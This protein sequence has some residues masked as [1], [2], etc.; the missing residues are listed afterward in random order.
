V[1]GDSASEELP[2]AIIKWLRKRSIFHRKFADILTYN[3]HKLPAR[4]GF[5]GP[6]DGIGAPPL[7]MIK[8][9]LTATISFV[10]PSQ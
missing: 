4:L 8:I 9:E 3:G 2:Q 5:S 10:P 7:T 6:L 1:S